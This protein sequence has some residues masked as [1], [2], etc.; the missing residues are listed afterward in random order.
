MRSVQELLRNRRFM[1]FWLGQAVSVV[2]DGMAPIAAAALAL[3]YH[4]ATGL[5][6]VLAATSVGYGVALLGGGV[7]AD[8]FSRTSVMALGDLLRAG[9]VCVLIVLFGRAPLGVICAFAAVVG[10]GMALFQPA[11]RAALTQLLPADQLRRAN[12]LQGIVNRGGFVLGAALAGILVA[13]VGP[14]LAYA[15]DAA[16]FGVSIATLLVIRLPRVPREG[17]SGLAGALRDAGEGLKVV[18]RVPWAAIVM[19]QGTLQV[20]AGFAPIHVL[21]PIVATERYGEAAFG[22]LTAAEGVGLIVG[23]ALA[24]RLRPRREGVAAMH[25]VA[26]IGLVCLCFAVPVP[27]WVFATVQVVGWTGIGVFITLWFPALQ[28][29]FPHAVQGRVFALES[30]ATF[31]L[32]PV[33]LMLTP[34]LA[35]AVGVPALGIT[36]AVVIVVSSYAVLAVRGV[37]TLG[38]RPRAAGPQ[39]APEP[40]AAAV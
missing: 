11:Y 1:I 39:S 36:T 26:V 17:A 25:G 28:R 19:A 10:V 7:I 37:P 3:R 23:S 35:G 14:R 20:L 5:G 24:L 38:Q 12:A 21:L 30:L 6:A 29:E 18:W 33:G 16:T 27:M 9:S 15:V 13:T 32:Q 4:G 31:A 40:A 8:R 34:W 22:L 2:G